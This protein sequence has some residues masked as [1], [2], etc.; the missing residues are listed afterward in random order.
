MKRIFYLILALLVM[1]PITAC[2]GKTDDSKSTEGSTDDTKAPTEAATVFPN[3]AAMS[4][5]Q[6]V[7]PGD[8]TSLPYPSEAAMH[9]AKNLYD[10]F[11]KSY[12]Q[13]VTDRAAQTGDYVNIDYAGYLDGVAFSG[14]TASSQDVFIVSD[15]GYI[16]GFV[17]G[18]PG[19]AIGEEFD[20][21]VTFPKNYGSADLAGKSV[22]FK[23]KL[24]KIYDL[25]LS[26]ETVAQKT[27]GKY[28]TYDAL[29]Q[30][31]KNDYAGPVLMDALVSASSFA[32]LPAES[33]QFFAERLRTT[34]REYASYYGM[35]YEKLLATYGITESDFEEFAKEQAKTYVLS[36]AL[37][38]QHGFE[39]DNATFEQEWEKDLQAFMKKNGYT[40]E[41]AE[42]KR[43]ESDKLE[44]RAQ[45]TYAAAVKWLALQTTA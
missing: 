2:Q 24:N 32:T 18:I 16:P 38:K 34:Y 20:V 37:A 27:D 40:R 31:Y 5:E 30:I 1:L 11:D 19:H 13:T 10:E 8:Y 35:E 14:G 45:L 3:Y 23:M 9:A 28:T 29:L 25:K 22:V 36:F 6:L 42:A 15:S 12:T 44:F 43:T 39:I 26:D 4:C 17:E 7:T 41:Q 21:P 33:Y